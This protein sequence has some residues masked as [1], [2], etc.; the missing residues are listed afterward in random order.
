MFKFLSDLIT[1]PIIKAAPITCGYIEYLWG[2]KIMRRLRVFPSNEDIDLYAYSKEA[3]SRFGVLRNQSHLKTPF[4]LMAAIPDVKLD[5]ILCIGPRFTAELCVAES[6][7]WIRE[8]IK[9][10]DLFTFSKR[11]DV[12]DMHD[13]PYENDSFSNVMAA[14][15]LAYSKKPVEAANEFMRVLSPG[16][17]LY[18]SGDSTFRL[19]DYDKFFSKCSRIFGVEGVSLYNSK[20]PDL[21]NNSD[22]NCTIAIY[23]KII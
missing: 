17:Y 18:V 9:A 13:M 8:G 20:Y 16:G 23:K 10:I 4:G 5:S 21:V 2:Y 22:K 15:L 11:I 3:F 19:H 14:R 12:G 6:F 7:G 1:K